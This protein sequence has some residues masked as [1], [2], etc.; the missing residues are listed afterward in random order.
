MFILSSGFLT[1]ILHTFTLFNILLVYPF[2][3]DVQI[4]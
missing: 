4:Y 3:L 2:Y 1:N